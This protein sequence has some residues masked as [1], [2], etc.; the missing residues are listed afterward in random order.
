[1]GCA[2]AKDGEVDII[3]SYADKYFALPPDNKDFLK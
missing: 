1:M 2:Q 3:P